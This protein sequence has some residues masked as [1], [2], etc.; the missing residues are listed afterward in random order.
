VRDAVGA[1]VLDLMFMPDASTD[2]LRRALEQTLH[3]G[4]QPRLFTSD[5]PAAGRRADGSTFPID[6]SVSRT[7]MDGLPHLT[8]VIRDVTEWKRAEESS[9]W[10]RRV[11]ESIAT[12]VELRDV[13]ATIAR[14]HETQCP[15]IDCAIHLID[16]DGVTL[17]FASAP[18]TRR[19]LSRCRSRRPSPRPST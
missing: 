7:Q 18:S 8:I 4:E 5:R 12:G 3:A 13:L 17:R 2:E 10:Q 6:I 11:L 9:E 16:D 15:G 19:S 1:S 14:F